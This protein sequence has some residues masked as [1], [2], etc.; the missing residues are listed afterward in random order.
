MKR[1]GKAN[2]ATICCYCRKRGL[3]IEAPLYSLGHDTFKNTYLRSCS[4]RNTKLTPY[5]QYNKIKI[6]I[7]FLSTFLKNSNLWKNSYRSDLLHI[8]KLY[9]YIL[10]G[11]QI[12]NLDWFKN[13]NSYDIFH[14][15]SNAMGDISSCLVTCLNSL[16]PLAST[17]RTSKTVMR[18]RKSQ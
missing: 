7:L 12:S 10:C 6:F 4:K 14:L 1:T 13:Q 3:N 11:Q 9:Q 5:I 18:Y 17:E 8:I 2:L 15:V 16:L